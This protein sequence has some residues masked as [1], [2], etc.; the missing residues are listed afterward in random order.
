M[1]GQIACQPVR[2][3]LYSVPCGGSYTRV[4]D[5][6]QYELKDHLG[7]V[8]VTFSDLKEPVLCSDLSQGWT[9]P[10]LPLTTT[11]ALVWHSPAGAITWMSIPSALTVRKMIMRSMGMEMRLT[12]GHVSMTR[13]WGGG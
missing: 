10:L 12:L 7:N 9:A 4:V 5:Q 6:K 8:R 13:G 1:N 3:N 11:T 2:M